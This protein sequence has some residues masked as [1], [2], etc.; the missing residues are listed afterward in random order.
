VGGSR[1]QQRRAQRG[2]VGDGG[3]P[4]SGSSG[5]APVLG[6]E[7]DDKGCLGQPEHDA[8]RLKAGEVGQDTTTEAGV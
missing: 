1:H 5:D 4:T 8:D 6:G 3:E 2:S 7:G